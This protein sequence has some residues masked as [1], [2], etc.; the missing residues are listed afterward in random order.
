MHPSFR[1][2]HFLRGFLEGCQVGFENGI[3]VGEH[4]SSNDTF[5]IKKAALSV[6]HKC[7]LKKFI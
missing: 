3:P 2:T 1:L 7:C 5:S 4:K 6:M